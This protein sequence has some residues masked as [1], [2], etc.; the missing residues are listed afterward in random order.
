MKSSTLTE[1]QQALAVRGEWL[2]RKGLSDEEIKAFTEA[3]GEPVSLAEEMAN[4]RAVEELERIT[5]SS[6]QLRAWREKL[7]AR[8]K[9][10]PAQDGD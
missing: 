6:D 7:P 1:K 9:C 4:L 5:P 8:D 3:Y 2:R 10:S